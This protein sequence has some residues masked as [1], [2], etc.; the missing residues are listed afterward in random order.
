MQTENSIN[1]TKRI[2]IRTTWMLFASCKYKHQI[3]KKEQQRQSIALQQTHTDHKTDIQQQNKQQATST[4]F[5]CHRI[6]TKT[7]TKHETQTYKQST[8]TN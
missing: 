5:I 2:T 6:Q 3:N 7:S 4:D 1:A 8:T